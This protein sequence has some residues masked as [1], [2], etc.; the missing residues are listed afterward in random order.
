M[1]GRT[2]DAARKA[3]GL[4]PLLEE[5]QAGLAD[6]P[7]ESLAVVERTGEAVLESTYGDLATHVETTTAWLRDQGVETGDV[8]AV[9]L[10]NWT[11][12]VVW[13]FALANLGACSLGVNTR[14]SVHELSNLLT[15]GR[16]VGI[17]MPAEFLGL[18]FEG[19]LSQAWETVAA[20]PGAA[21]PPWVATVRDVADG[22]QSLDLGGGTL[23]VPPLGAAG[24]G[25]GDASSSLFPEEIV[26][27]FTTSGSSGNPKLAGHDQRAVAEHS[28]N[29]V[30]A[31]DMDSAGSFLS[32]LPLT[33]VFGFN[34]SM[35]MLAAG[36]CLLLEP[37]FD[38]PTVLADMERFG[39]S[40]VVGG[41]DMLGRLMDGWDPETMRPTVRRG[42]IADFAGRAVAFVEWAEEHWESR[43]GGVYGSSEVF[44]LT[45]TW[46]GDLDLE[47]RARGGGTPVSPA[48]GV[49]VA[50]PESDR[51]LAAEE[52]GE[53]QFRGYNVLDAYVGTPGLMEQAVTADGWFRSGDLGLMTGEGTDFVYVCRNSDALRL[54]G[55]LVEPEEIERFL[56]SYPP[57]ETA[58]V[59]GAAGGEGDVAVA[60]V[61]LRPGESAEP[62]DVLDYCRGQLARFK[63]PSL[64]EIIDEFPVTTGTNG[65]KIRTAV[66]RERAA[67]LLE[68]EMTRREAE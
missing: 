21:P 33:G 63:V 36:G 26:N 10:P 31:L 39:V 61:T 22:G 24:P 38:V 41:D 5:M 56:M 28:R 64:V 50:D 67:A 35:G 43:I 49:R 37:T 53:L 29:V 55:F 45:A 42:G 14:Y 66:L 15:R 19:R 48:I 68:D 30:A 17:L 58:R 18:D 20:Q 62:E 32:V 7:P 23:S 1:A 6:P 11:E 51:V 34:P 44:A 57:V 60:F 4:P 54:R 46:A 25:G 13:Q 16:P 40:H 65:T 12:L 3:P 2:Q 47:R 27:C 8:I 9:W 59:V 52:L